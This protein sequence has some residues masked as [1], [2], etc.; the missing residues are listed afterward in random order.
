[1]YK[2]NSMFVKEKKREKIGEIERDGERVVKTVFYEVE[3]KPKFHL[4]IC[5]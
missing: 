5:E 3:N 2:Y 1:M 4:I